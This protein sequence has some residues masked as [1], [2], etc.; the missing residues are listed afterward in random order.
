VQEL[1]QKILKKIQTNSKASDEYLGIFNFF[2]FVNAFPFFLTSPL[3]SLVI[4]FRG[5]Y[6]AVRVGWLPVLEQ[7]K[8]IEVDNNTILFKA[9]LLP[10][11][12]TP[13]VNLNV[14]DLPS[15]FARAPFF[16]KMRSPKQSMNSF[17]C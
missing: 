3:D 4:L 1:A 5:P 8:E 9:R 7:S 12:L 17:R 10:S 15:P 16:E 13:E 6:Y 14:P 11:L 2:L